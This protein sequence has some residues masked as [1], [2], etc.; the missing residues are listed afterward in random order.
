M[1]LDELISPAAVVVIKDDDDDDND[2]VEIPEEGEDDSDLV[3]GGINDARD[4]L[5][6]ADSATQ[7]N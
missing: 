1:V 5:V 6:E 3:G 2:D 7:L 4:S